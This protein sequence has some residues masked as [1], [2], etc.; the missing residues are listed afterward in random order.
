M[1]S[2]INPLPTDRDRRRRWSTLRT[3]VARGYVCSRCARESGRWVY[4]PSL[5]LLRPP[6][7]AYPALGSSPAAETREGVR[8][9][10][11]EGKTRKRDREREGELVNK[12]RCRIMV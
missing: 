1:T 3:A 4:V 7:Y 6:S 5:L 12:K 11:G 9:G 8:E 10:G 2:I